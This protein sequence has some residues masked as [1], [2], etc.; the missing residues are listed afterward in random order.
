MVHV[1]YE[2]ENKV[3]YFMLLKLLMYDIC[4][5]LFSENELPS[6]K[7]RKSRLQF[8]YVLWYMNLNKLPPPPPLI[9][10]LSDKPN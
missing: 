6:A 8:L 3:T 10:P 9:S 4:L 1:F 7:T 5:L 2:T